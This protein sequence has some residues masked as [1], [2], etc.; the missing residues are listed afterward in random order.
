MFFK[1]VIILVAVLIFCIFCGPA[2]AGWEPLVELTALDS[3]EKV[4][5]KSIQQSKR[6]GH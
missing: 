1:R 4:Y 6:L 2:L 3:N 5:H